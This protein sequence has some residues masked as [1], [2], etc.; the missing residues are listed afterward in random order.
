MCRTWDTCPTPD[1]ITHTLSLFYFCFLISVSET[2]FAIH[3]DL[4][5][6]KSG[7]LINCITC[8]SLRTLS[9]NQNAGGY[10]LT[11][12]VVLQREIKTHPRCIL[13][14]VIQLI[15]PL[16]LI[17]HSC[18]LAKGQV[19]GPNWPYFIFLGIVFYFGTEWYMRKSGWSRMILILASAG[20]YLCTPHRISVRHYPGSCV[21]WG[22]KPN[23]N[24]G[25]FA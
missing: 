20:D 14:I 17:F 11:R 18:P 7:V 22:W 13:V 8:Q 6:G 19:H 12:S 25:T 24:P 16:R 21:F 23:K 4:L 10:V 5:G 9:A 15:V 3:V 1:Y 2:W